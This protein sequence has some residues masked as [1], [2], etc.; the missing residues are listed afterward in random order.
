MW[1]NRESHSLRDGTRNSTATMEDS[2][3]VSYEAKCT[4]LIPSST[5]TLLYLLK[6]VEN[7]SPHKHLHTDVYSSFII[8]AKSYKQPK[9]TSPGEWTTKLWCIEITE[10]CTALKGNELS[11][12]EKKETNKN[13]KYILLN[14]KMSI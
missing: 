11:S 1:S 3:V 4:L 7:L 2:L 10:Y 14:E 5:L 8:I 12:R 6:R 9:Y 13:L